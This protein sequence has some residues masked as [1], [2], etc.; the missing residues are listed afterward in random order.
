MYLDLASLSSWLVLEV[1]LEPCGAYGSSTNY[2][3]LQFMASY[4]LCISLNGE[5]SFHVSTF[6]VLLLPQLLFKSL[7]NLTC[8]S[9][10]MFAARPAFYNYI[11]IMFAFGAVTL[12]ACGLAGIRAGYGIW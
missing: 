8:S 1:Q 11:L 3:L 5:K 12:L 7:A 9:V 2:C 4:C 6:L 10:L